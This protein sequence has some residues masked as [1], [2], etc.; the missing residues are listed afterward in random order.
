MRSSRPAVFVSCLFLHADPFL[1]T[2]APPL[3]FPPPASPRIPAAG[4]SR[5]PAP[6]GHAHWGGAL[7]LRDDGGR[8]G[9]SAAG[10][11][12]LL[13]QPVRAPRPGA[14]GPRRVRLRPSRAGAPPS[15]P[16]APCFPPGAAR[17]GS[18][19]EGGRA[20]GGRGPAGRAA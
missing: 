11:P 9:L 12:A 13:L 15:S 19:G 20:R 1:R 18:P 16:R 10:L 17:P 14:A 4:V 7:R 2:P 3:P 6:G 8:G 5:A